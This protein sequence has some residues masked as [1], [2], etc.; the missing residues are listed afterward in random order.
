MLGEKTTPIS[1]ILNNNNVTLPLL[2]TAST[3]TSL[4][5]RM[6]LV[7]T[8]GCFLKKY[9][10]KQFLEFKLNELTDHTFLKMHDQF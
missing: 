5:P 9:S 10:K 4:A 1:I 3:S 8:T 2:A 7:M 6:N